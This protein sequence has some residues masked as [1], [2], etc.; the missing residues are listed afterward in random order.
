MFIPPPYPIPL[1]A[2]KTPN[3]TSVRLAGKGQKLSGWP[4]PPPATIRGIYDVEFVVE[5]S[6]TTKVPPPP[7]TPTSQL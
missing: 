3:G 7:P 6:S 5:L 4:A 2:P 1:I